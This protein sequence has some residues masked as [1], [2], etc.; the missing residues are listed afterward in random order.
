MN[1]VEQDIIYR[2]HQLD[3]EKQRQ[4]LDFIE[5]LRKQPPRHYS[6][7]EL[8]QLPAAERDRI[9]AE[10]FRLAENEDFEIFEAYSEEPLD[11]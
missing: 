10:A 9:V 5:Q 6:P 1:T 3:P 4:V 7:R 8:M 11:E 2:L